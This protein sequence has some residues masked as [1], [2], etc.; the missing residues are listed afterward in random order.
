[1][2]CNKCENNVHH[3]NVRP[4]MYIVRTAN[5]CSTQGT[6]SKR[7]SV[8]CRGFGVQEFRVVYVF[9]FSG[10]RFRFIGV[11]RILKFFLFLVL[12]VFGFL[13]LKVLG[14]KVKKKL[15]ARPKA[16]KERT[17]NKFNVNFGRG[18]TNFF[19]LEVVQ[20]RIVGHT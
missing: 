14:S 5:T 11:L 16:Q 13:G 20:K 3:P 10:F 18:L 6:A 2:D 1:M 9:G 7:N 12:E 19:F 17:K 4:S 15:P 8:Q